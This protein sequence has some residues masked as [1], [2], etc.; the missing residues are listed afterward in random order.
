MTCLWSYA[1]ISPHGQHQQQPS[2]FGTLSL[3][4]LPEFSVQPPHEPFQRTDFLP[5][6]RDLQFP[7][8]QSNPKN[9]ALLLCPVF[10]I[11]C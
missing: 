6:P 9:T 10:K 8:I 7:Q 1:T 5:S 2:R 4:Q 3:L 11:P